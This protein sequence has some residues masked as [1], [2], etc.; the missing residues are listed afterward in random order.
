V[1]VAERCFLR[2]DLTQHLLERYSTTVLAD[3]NCIWWNAVPPAKYLVEWRSTAFPL[4]HST[5]VDNDNLNLTISHNNLNNTFK[6]IVLFVAIM[7]AKQ[8]VGGSW[9]TFHMAS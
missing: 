7:A 9:L 8:N 2:Q 3:T 6:Y 4:H 1:S 5:A